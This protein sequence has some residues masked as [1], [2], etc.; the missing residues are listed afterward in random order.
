MARYQMLCRVGVGTRE[1]VCFG[2]ALGLYVLI[3]AGAA[4]LGQKFLKAAESVNPLSA[5][6]KFHLARSHAWLGDWSQCLGGLQDTL[7][8]SPDAE[9]VVLYLA[10]VSLRIGGYET[11]AATL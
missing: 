7:R 5:E 8:M 10:L 9:I 11:A 2:Y 6:I 1:G 3:P 4:E